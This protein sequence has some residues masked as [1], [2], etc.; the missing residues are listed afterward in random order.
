MA[1][2]RI[3]VC[4]KVLNSLSQLER[5]R[6]KGWSSRN[7]LTF[8][9]KRSRSPLCLIISARLPATNG[10]NILIKRRCFR[11][12]KEKYILNI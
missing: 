7:D 10:E 5:V 9:F 3:L 1:A 12:E 4:L 2:E 8:L 11:G 6:L